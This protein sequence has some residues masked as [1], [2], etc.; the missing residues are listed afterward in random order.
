MNEAYLLLWPIG[1]LI[2][3]LPSK[4]QFISLLLTGLVAHGVPRA[5]L[6][7]RRLLGRAPNR[8]QFRAALPLRMPVP[9]A[10]GPPHTAHV[11]CAPSSVS[12]SRRQHSS[13]GEPTPTATTFAA[14]ADGISSAEPSARGERARPFSLPGPQS[15]TGAGGEG[16]ELVERGVPNRSIALVVEVVHRVLVARVARVP[17]RRR[18]RRGAR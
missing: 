18:R 6:R 7:V 17:R 8:P 4:H 1:S 5:K 2:T 10:K 14:G 9:P 12:L 3:S 15:C 13:A 16:D 11:G